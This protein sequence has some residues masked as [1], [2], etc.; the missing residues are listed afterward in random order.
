[1]MQD[2]GLED[3]WLIDP[4]LLQHMTGTPRW[5]SSLTPVMH[6]QYIIFGDNGR[7]SI[8]SVRVNDDFVLSVS[9]WSTLCSLIGISCTLVFFPFVPLY[10]S[11]L[12]D[13]FVYYAFVHFAL[14]ILCICII[15]CSLAPFV[16]S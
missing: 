1:M 2:G 9:L 12:V 16:C 6:M 3:L 5:F 15:S 8:R 4:G 14:C 7:G 10:T 11:F 13:T